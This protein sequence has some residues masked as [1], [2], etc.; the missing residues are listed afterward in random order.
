MDSIQYFKQNDQVL[1]RCLFIWACEGLSIPKALHIDVWEMAGVTAMAAGG[2]QTQS[3]HA[4]D[5]SLGA[6]IGSMSL[7]IMRSPSTLN[8]C[9]FGPLLYYIYSDYS[10]HLDNGSLMV[11]CS[12]CRSYNSKTLAQRRSDQLLPPIHQFHQTLIWSQFCTLPPPSHHQQPSYH[13]PHLHPLQIRHEWSKPHPQLMVAQDQITG[14]PIGKTICYS[15]LY[16][17]QMNM[18]SIGK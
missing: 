5:V 13:R 16:L 1:W 7:L 12:S 10:T 17:D 6:R 18:E 3:A 9:P 4:C 15:P 14:V 11:I 8:K 2:E